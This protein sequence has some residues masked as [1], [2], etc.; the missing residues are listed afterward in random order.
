MLGFSAVLRRLVHDDSLAA[1][2]ATKRHDALVEL[3]EAL[4]GLDG[5]DAWRLCDEMRAVGVVEHVAACVSDAEPNV[6]REALMLLAMLT[7]TDVDAAADKSVGLLRD[8]G[9]FEHVANRLFS[10]E[11]VLTIALVVGVCTNAVADVE[12]LHV[13]ETCG[14]IDR[15]RELCGCGQ[16]SVEQ[17]AL[18]CLHNID[19]TTALATRAFDAVVRLQRAGRRRIAARAGL[20]KRKL[21]IRSPD[22]RR[23]ARCLSGDLESPREPP[24]LVWA[25]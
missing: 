7:T 9:C 25:A 23:A 24:S 5:K 21:C 15:L 10:A 4:D 19:A 11:D 6:H 18:A 14:G 12:C 16:P 17:A 20:H 2:S 13:L 1:A 22:L 8:S 3:I